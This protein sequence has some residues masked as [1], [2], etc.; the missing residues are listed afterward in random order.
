[1][2][3]ALSIIFFT[4]ASGAGLGLAR[5]AR[6]RRSLPGAAVCRRRRLPRGIALALLL[7]AAGLASSVLHLAK[8]SNAWRAFCALPHVVAVA[9]GGACGAALSAG[10]RLPAS[11]CALDTAGMA[12]ALA[13]DRGLPARVGGAVLHGDDLREPEADPAVADRMDAG[14]VSAARPLVGRADRWSRSP[15]AT[16]ASRSPGH[17]SRRCSAWRRLSSSSATGA[18]APPIAAASRR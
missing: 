17:G 16:A 1:M 5:A 4:V 8:P 13:G 9:R 15:S 10:L 7:I 14:G 6:A 11:R 12:R 3:P 18:T 2:K